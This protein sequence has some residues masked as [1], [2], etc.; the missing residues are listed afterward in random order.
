[1]SADACIGLVAAFADDSLD[2]RIHASGAL[3][4]GGSTLEIPRFPASL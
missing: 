1:L 4:G 3:P 2:A